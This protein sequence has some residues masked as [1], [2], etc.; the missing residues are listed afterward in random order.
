MT[1]SGVNGVHLSA[2]LRKKKSVANTKILIRDA[3]VGAE[4]LDLAF[5]Q[6]YLRKDESVHIFCTFH[7]CLTCSS[8]SRAKS[9]GLI[10][11]SEMIDIKVVDT[12]QMSKAWDDS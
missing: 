9:T 5:L 2:R 1:M 4:A 7:L 10:S 8:S 11:L 6:W 3:T 12:C